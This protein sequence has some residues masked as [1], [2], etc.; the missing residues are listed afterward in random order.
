MN[1]KDIMALVKKP[2]AVQFMTLLKARYNARSSFA[3]FGPAVSQCLQDI[4]VD[5]YV[6]SNTAEAVVTRM[7]RKSGIQ[8]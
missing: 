2:Q 7:E 6:S 5:V 4:G 8:F 3:D 1:Y